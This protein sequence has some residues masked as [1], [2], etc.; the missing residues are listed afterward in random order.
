M[1][2]HPQ[3]QGLDA[4][5]D[6]EGVEGRERRAEI[7]QAEHPAGDRE[8][9]IAEGLAENHAA[10][11]RP[12]LREHRVAVVARQVERAAV[13]DHAADRIAVSAQELGG[14]MHDDVGAVLE[15]AACR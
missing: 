15:G 5:E 4:V 11:F 6:Q 9:E 2:L 1:A 10:I 7:A 8:G 3:R 12:G 13:D 14:R